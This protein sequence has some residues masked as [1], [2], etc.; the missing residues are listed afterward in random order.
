MSCLRP[1]KAWY[2]KSTAP[3]A[4]LVFDV[5]F[6]AHPDR[7]CYV[8]CD[9]CIGCRLYKSQAWAVRCMHEKRVHQSSCFVTL[10]YDPKNLP[11][12][13]TLVRDAVP[14]F[15]ARLRDYL[16]YPPLSFFYC[17]EYGDLN[18][19]PHYHEIIFGYDPPDKKFW[20]R[21]RGQDYFTSELLSDRWGLGNVVIGSVDFDSAAYVARY[22]LKK[23]KASDEIL[24]TLACPVTGV[25][26][27][28]RYFDRPC[29]DIYTREV[30][31]RYPVFAGMSTNPAIGR[32]FLE[33]YPDDVYAQMNT[34][35]KGH[36]IALPRYY[37]KVLEKQD[38]LKYRLFKQKQKL[39]ACL[40]P[41]N[42]ARLEA[43]EKIISA[44]IKPLSRSLDQ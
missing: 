32:R 34:V 22:T 10:T 14:K 13:G 24:Y 37:L 17:G 18:G 29:S 5:R 44:R 41:P 20:K 6:A 8:S 39:E 42:Y 4:R 19:R 30:Y 27:D 15:N 3:D 12:H 25:V 21:V 26:F 16:N 43:R 11:P 36:E 2:P 33:R 40:N 28:V 38:P 31:N 7:S 23:Q 35:F 9:Q 1:I